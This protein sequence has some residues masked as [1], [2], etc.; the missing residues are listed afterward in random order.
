[1]T[2][3]PATASDSARIRELSLYSRSGFD[4]DEELARP[5]ARLWVARASPD[6]EPLGFALVWHAADEVQLLDLAVDERARRRGVGR[7]LVRFVLA[8]ARETRSRLVL[9][10]VRRSNEAAIA[11]YRSAGFTEN[12]VRRGYY[13]DNG[14]DALAMSVELS[15]TR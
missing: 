11:L 8:Y 9:L 3:S 10:E 6:G 5:W 12:G 7:E 1:M 15:E 14:E 2:V 13:S 4:P